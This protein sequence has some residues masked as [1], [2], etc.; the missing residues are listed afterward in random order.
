[1]MSLRG[2]LILLVLLA[3]LPAVALQIWNA[4]HLNASREAEIHA[5]VL[6]QAVALAAEQEQMLDGLRKLLS[7][8]AQ[9]PVVINQDRAGCGS[10]MAKIIASSPD[11]LNLGA[12]ALDGEAFCSASEPPASKTPVMLNDR[13]YFR[14]ALA[15]NHFIVGQVN[16][17]RF[18]DVHALPV[19][20]P[21]LRDGIPAGIVFASL[22]L[23]VLAQRLGQRG[24]SSDLAFLIG[25]RVGVTVARQPDHHNFVGTP[26]PATLQPLLAGKEPGVVETTGIDG[27]TRIIGYVPPAAGKSGLYFGVGVTRESAFSALS[28]TNSRGA[29]V[30]AVGAVLTILLAALG[31][32]D[33]IVRPLAHLAGTATRLSAGEWFTR[34]PEDHGSP[35]MVTL[36][37]AMNRMAE[38][39]QSSL[40]QKDMLLREVHHRVMNGLTM[41]A[42]LVTLQAHG[43]SDREG[44]EALAET[45]RRIQA[46]ALAYRRLHVASAVTDVQMAEYLEGLCS[47]IGQSLLA[48][49]DTQTIAVEADAE[50][51]PIDK[52]VPIGLIV[53]ELVTNALKYAFPDRANGHVGVSFRQNG[54]MWHLTV[55]DNGI[56]LPAGFRPDSCNGLG[57]RVVVLL[58]K[59][60]NGVLAV[61]RE[62][63]GAKFSIVLPI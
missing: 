53:S 4:M 57:M 12:A 28:E 47:D 27:V 61:D 39:I 43:I 7:A 5:T 41:L 20:V 60:M 10:T 45:S 48:I 52:A 40:A 24:W 15:V 63:R 19:A 31:A 33:A 18:L 14:E 26:F 1:V 29:V 22:N 58:V 17:G 50:S 16:K 21:Y 46:L 44:Q 35:E 2:R 11:L 49:G 34:A 51:L 9:L 38:T 6:R 25:D 37:R 30:I 62:H 13:P 23:D 36:A 8:V 32:Q 55:E 56:G 3:V 42:G 54:S 59:Q